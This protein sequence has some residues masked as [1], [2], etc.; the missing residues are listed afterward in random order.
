[1][2]ESDTP[3]KRTRCPG[4]TQKPTVTTI[5]HVVEQVVCI[6]G[7]SPGGSSRQHRVI[8]LPRN[9]LPTALVL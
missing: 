1:M 2:V 6:T 8:S 4:L 7:T 9:T 5:N 3:P